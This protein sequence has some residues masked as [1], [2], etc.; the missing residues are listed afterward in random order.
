[1]AGIHR[2]DEIRREF[3]EFFRARGHA[4]VAAS[5]LVPL[6]DP[7]LLF[8]TAGMVQF[9]PLYAG[10]GPLPYTRAAST[11][12]CLRATD[13]DSVGHTARH[14]TFF[15]MLGNFSFG[16][17]FKRESCGW[18]FELVTEVYGID[19][20]LLWVTVYETD[21]EAIGIWRDIGIP[22]DRI[23]RRGKA[24][25]YWWTH[26]AGPAGPCS[27]IYVDRGPRY[28]EAGGPAVDEG[29]HMEIWNHV[30]MQD[31]VDQDQTILHELP[32]P[33]RV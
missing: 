28:G 21:D 10:E 15:E 13:L 31:E 7:S 29:R 6:R 33:T 4:V 32:A 20:E 9:K 11:Q 24:D 12:P 14:L 16:D 27:E 25:N 30:F 3:L 26:A 17:Y 19:P 1:M 18:G 8:T 5:P 23:V 2:S 22:V